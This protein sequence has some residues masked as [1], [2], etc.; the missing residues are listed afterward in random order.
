MASVSFSGNNYSSSSSSSSSS[1]HVN[2]NNDTSN[3][4]NNDSS[5]M[6][7]M[8]PLLAI[9]QAPPATTSSLMDGSAMPSFIKDMDRIA[10]QNTV[11]SF[12]IEKERQ[13]KVDL[14][15]SIDA[16]RRQLRGIQDKTRNGT[17]IRDGEYNSKKQI[18]RIE[19]QLQMA[20]IKLS[21]SRRDNG[22]IKSKI[23]EARKDK[24]LC[25]QIIHDLE[26][27][28]ESGK[29]TALN[30]QREI[31][32]L[33]DK[34]YKI[35]IEITN[36]KHKLL[37]EMEDF[38]RELHLAKNN[39]QITQESIMEEMHHRQLSTF[40]SMYS[41]IHSPRPPSHARSKTPVIEDL[42]GKQQIIISELLSEVGVDS[43][44]QLIQILQTSEDEIFH[45]YNEIQSKNDEN[46]KL[47]ATI[48]HLEQEL[49]ERIR[50]L[51]MLE[52]NTQKLKS[53]L[54][55]N[56]EHIKASM[57]KYDRDYSKNLEVL[58]SA[59]PN[60]MLLLK[61]IS[62]E[63]EA[64]DQQLLSTGPT[65]R[66]IDEMLGLIEQRVDDL[67]QIK[68]AA[69]KNQ[70]K[71]DDF[72]KLV[73]IIKPVALSVPT[74]PSFHDIDKDE[75]GDDDDEDGDEKRKERVERVVPVHIQALKDSMIKKYAPKEKQGW[76]SSGKA[77]RRIISRDSS[78]TESLRASTASL[79]DNN[80]AD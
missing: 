75:K 11:F 74:L 23:D 19:Y 48:K 24:L 42:E 68:V 78:V 49:Q 59:S 4:T 52:E 70:L 37:R 43:L 28:L 21:V 12:K 38:S 10:K 7:T 13:R 50:Q 25:M 33:S 45:I 71:K 32:F 73:Q 72:T 3:T 58:N 39:I 9:N 35:K 26:Q 57:A 80:A 15:S 1:S 27:E 14:D 5:S 67:I 56:I 64:L 2:D 6:P 69:Q 16:A 40:N 60:L 53:E 46:E 44:E 30:A 55:Q 54:E 47:D 22:T 8:M 76:T 36:L 65:D 17:I 31:T 51:E 18:N 29:N 34:K 20:R 63:E 77:I 79:Q 62:D 41:S 61:H 66:N